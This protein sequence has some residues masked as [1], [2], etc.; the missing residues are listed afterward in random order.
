ME[1]TRTLRKG[2]NGDDVLYAKQ[3]LVELG[4]LF[5]A[6]KRTFGSDTLKAVKA[7]QNANGLEAD[8]IIGTLTWAAL[9]PASGE[10]L[11]VT[12]VDIPDRFSAAIR[13]AI[14]VDLAQVSDIRREI[15]LDAL[16]FAIDP[17]H[18]PDYPVSLYIRG[19]NLYN[20]DLS[21]NIITTARIHS[22][23]AR[24]PE[25]YDGGRMEMMLEAVAADPNTTGG[26]CSGGIIGLMRKHGIYPPD[27]DATANTL[28][29]SHCV[30]TTTPQPGDWACKSGHIGIYVGGGY[31]VEWAGGEYGC[32]LTKIKDRRCYSFTDCR[33][34]KMSKWEFFGDPKR[35]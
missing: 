32:Q 25:Y 30:K 1:F 15:C 29:A 27:F 20:K 14:G 22:G 3:R 12:A 24:Q 4:F 10:V 6:T 28:A 5:A 17:Y 7:F 33:L 26:D 8:G 35:Y 31:V 13:Q 18:P 34:E 23:A 21:P 19:G 9:F 16:R 11:T 2:M